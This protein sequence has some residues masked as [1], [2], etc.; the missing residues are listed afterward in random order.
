GYGRVMSITFSTAGGVGEEQ[1]EEIN[2]GLGDIYYFLID[3]H[4]GRYNDWQRSFQPLPLLVRNTEEQMEEEGADEEIEA[5]M[6]NKGD[7]DGRIKAWANDANAKL[8]NHFIYRR[9][10]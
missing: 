8:L 4:E 5:Q 2:V 10:R 6:N 9:R 1:D 3:L 7:N